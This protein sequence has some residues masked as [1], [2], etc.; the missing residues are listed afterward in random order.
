MRVITVRCKDEYKWSWAG[1]LDSND[2][3]SCLSELYV[4]LGAERANV[5]LYSICNMLAHCDFLKILVNSLL[6][7]LAKT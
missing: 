7:Q 4:Y 1:W 2:S 5:I 3:I 6:L